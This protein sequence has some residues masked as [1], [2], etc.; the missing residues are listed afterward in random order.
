MLQVLDFQENQLSRSVPPTI[1][2][3]ST[4]EK[5]YLTQNNLTG[6]FPGNQ[7]FSLPMIQEISL[8]RNKFIGRIPLG[9][10]EC[11]T[12]QVLDLGGNLFADHV[13]T[14]LAKLPQ[15]NFLS[16]GGNDLIGSIPGVLN[17]LTKL[18]ILD[19]SFSNLSGTILRNQVDRY[20]L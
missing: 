17:N 12:L 11:Q 9:L 16:I 2:N 6:A 7:S 5:L 8:G 4:L 20:L 1:F 14:W 13:P 18:S 10:A 3:M 19:L 15:L